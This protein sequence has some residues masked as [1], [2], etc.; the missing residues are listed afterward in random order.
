MAFFAREDSRDKAPER[1]L[2]EAVRKAGGD[3][4]AEESVKPWELPKWVIARARELGLQLE[5]DARPGADRAASAIASSGCCASSRSWRCR[6]GPR[7]PASTPLRSRSWRAPS[8]E[9]RA[10][11]LADAMVA[12]RRAGRRHA[13]Y[14]A[15][16]AQGERVPGLL[17]WMAQRVR[18]AHEIAQALDRPASRRHR[19][20]AGCGCR[21]GP[22]IG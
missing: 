10:W 11:S 16:R 15:L 5:P 14:L 22:P 4:S 7:V 8:A 19:S 6:G 13:L 2:H 18:T 12:R 20:S 21:R 9:R 17:Y 1:G 3:I